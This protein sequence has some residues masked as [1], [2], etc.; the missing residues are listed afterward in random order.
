MILTLG[1]FELEPLSLIYWI[2]ACL[3]ILVAVICVL[4]WVNNIFTGVG[5]GALTYIV[6]DKILRQLFI[7]K[8]DKPFTVTKTGIGIYILTWIFFWALI[9]TL[10][11][12]PV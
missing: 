2:K 9:F 3:G 12:R 7:D 8:V 10:L 4:F 6:S 11:N 1:E 5:I